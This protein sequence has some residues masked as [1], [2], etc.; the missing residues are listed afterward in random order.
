MV[1]AIFGKGDTMSKRGVAVMLVLLFAG[2]FASATVA[3]AQGG[4][5]LIHACVR[6]ADGGVRIVGP[7]DTCRTGETPLSWPATAGNAT[8]VSL[9]VLLA[10]ENIVTSENITGSWTD[11]PGLTAAFQTTASGCITATLSLE[12]QITAGKR[13]TARILL[14]GVPME[15]QNT[16]LTLAEPAIALEPQTTYTVL[17]CN[18]SSG[19]HV[20]N[21]QWRGGGDIGSFNQVIFFGRTL[22]VLGQ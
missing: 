10:N 21:V 13:P 20:I 5:T 8:A 16:Y 17:K 18:V 14:D 15:G 19:S 4:P 7:T 22:V 1:K 3:H 2:I 12:N 11:I 6:T 9:L